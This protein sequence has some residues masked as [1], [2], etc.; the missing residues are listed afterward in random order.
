MSLG[1]DQ[2]L[3][4]IPLQR[5]SQDCRFD[6]RLRMRHD[7]ADRARINGEQPV[8][9]VEHPPDAKSRTIRRHPLIDDGAVIVAAD[10]ISV[11]ST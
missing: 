11:G 9:H 10:K 5:A 1:D 4:K 6:K 8:V 3:G 7:V 2:P